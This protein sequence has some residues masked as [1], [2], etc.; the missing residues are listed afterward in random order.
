MDN[1]HVDP[2]IVDLVRQMADYGERIAA[3]EAKTDYR[4]SIDRDPNLLA[5]RVR[6]MVGEG[7]K[8]ATAAGVAGGMRRSRRPIPTGDL[9]PAKPKSW[10]MR[11][12][13]RGQP[14][15]FDPM[16]PPKIKGPLPPAHKG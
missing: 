13:G 7:L 6:E 15:Y 4:V 14:V 16:R 10:F 5:S 1:E 11:L 9:P 8:V 12:F 3:L 2:V